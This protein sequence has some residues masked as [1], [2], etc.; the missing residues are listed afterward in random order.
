MTARVVVVE[1]DQYRAFVKQLKAD[2]DQARTEQQKQSKEFS[3][4]GV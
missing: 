4:E 1:P 2:I 3:K